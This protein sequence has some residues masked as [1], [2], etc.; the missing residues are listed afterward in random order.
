[1][2]VFLLTALLMTSFIVPTFV[3]SAHS[4]GASFE[5]TVDGHVIDI[6]YDPPS[7][8][9]GD[10]LVFDLSLRELET[11]NIEHYKD[12]WVR[13]SQDDQLL[14]ATG[15]AESSFGPT[16]LLLRIPDNAKGPLTVSVR[17]ENA[18]KSLAETEFTIPVLPQESNSWLIPWV[19]AGMAGCVLGWL[20]GRLKV[21]LSL[22]ERISKVFKQ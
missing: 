11:R 21:I 17:F 2:K 20:L 19:I 14:L 6:G 7:P 13:V 8:V 22:Y 16:T 1:M 5:E 15:V 3:A 12:V 18:D 10:R 4:L 9:A